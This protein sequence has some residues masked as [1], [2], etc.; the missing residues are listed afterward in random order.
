MVVLLLV[1][2][3]W[4]LKC[5]TNH[6]QSRQVPDFTGLRADEAMKQAKKKGLQIVII[7]S[8]FQP[9][10]K[11]YIVL[12]QDPK[13]LSRVKE[14]RNIY[15]TINKK[16][17]PMTTFPTYKPG[18]SYWGKPY[19]DVRRALKSKDINTRVAARVYDAYAPNTVVGFI[20]MGDTLTEDIKKLKEVKLPMFGT[21]DLIVTESGGGK[22]EIPELIC[23]TFSEA[24]FML[25]T[26]N[27]NLGSVIP[28]GQIT[29]RNTAYVWRQNPPYEE[30]KSM[31]MGE[32][33]DVYISQY[34]P[35]GCTQETNRSNRNN[36]GIDEIGS[37]DDDVF[38]DEREEN[39]RPE[40]TPEPTPEQPATPTTPTEIIT[41]PE[42]ED[43]EFFDGGR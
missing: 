5:Y 31:R 6:N 28:D 17:A 35:D 37:L 4:G 22:I 12:D 18:E 10:R 36:G 24:Q 39:S 15:L 40:T 41:D 2:T 14:D 33:I 16:D 20:F 27:V 30:G 9:S 38:E 42:E 21:V 19:D 7:D 32:Q 13:A 34:R 29:N 43:D 3:F 8:T 26:M 1:L 25:S 23:L 11:P